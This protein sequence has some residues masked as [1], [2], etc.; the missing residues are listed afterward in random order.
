MRINCSTKIFWF[1]YWSILGTQVL[2][3]RAEAQRLGIGFINNGRNIEGSRIEFSTPEGYS[4]RFTDS[5]RPSI[6]GGIGVA[7][8]LVVPGTYSY[9]E[10]F[11]SR[12]HDPQPVGG[13]VLKIPL[14]NK[15]KNCD[16]ILRLEANN[17]SL[18]RAQELFEYGL[19][20]EEDM[21]KIAD[22]VYQNLLN[23]VENNGK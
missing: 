3:Q 18:L 5:D 22:K 6:T 23:T 10:T 14:G 13:V 4:C 2:F 17:I 11:P 12:I 21:K 20:E 19:I 8:P 16:E 1:A 15:P 9:E 7:D